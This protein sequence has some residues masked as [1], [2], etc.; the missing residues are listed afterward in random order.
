MYLL[1]FNGCNQTIH[2]VPTSLLTAYI[3]TVPRELKTI[4]DEKDSAVEASVNPEVPHS[5][6]PVPIATGT[7]D[8]LLSNTMIHF[9]G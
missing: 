8:V 4:E 6:L 1:C 5:F 9:T 7:E 3:D 2:S